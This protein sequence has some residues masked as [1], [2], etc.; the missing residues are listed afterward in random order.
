M[1]KK[2]SRDAKTKKENP[3]ILKKRKYCEKAD[4]LVDGLSD[5]N[6]N[7]KL[8]EERCEMDWEKALANLMT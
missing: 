5:F 3:G 7:I 6:K 2:A 1:A 4:K 8:K